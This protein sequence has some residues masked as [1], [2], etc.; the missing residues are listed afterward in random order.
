MKRFLFSVF[1]LFSQI[2]LLFPQSKM[3]LDN[4][5]NNFAAEFLMQIPGGSRIAVI[6][7]ETDKHDLMIHFIDSMVD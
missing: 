2:T 6:S 1:L 5:I 3:T 4:A 7:F